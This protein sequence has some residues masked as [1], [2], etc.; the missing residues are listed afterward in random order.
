VNF[1]ERDSAWKR[2]LK[3]VLP[4]A[5]QD[6]LWNGY[7]RLV[8]RKNL[9]VGRRAAPAE[10]S[11]AK[12]RRQREGFFDLYCQGRGLD[13]G[14]GGDP[15]VRGVRGWD[16]E[17]GDA[18][19]LQS[20]Q[21]ASFDFVYSSHTLEHMVDP[22]VSVQNWWR[23]VKPGGYL[24]LYVPHRDLYEKKKTLPSQWN[25]DHKSFLLPEA[26]DPPDTVGLRPLLEAHCVG[27]E[28]VYLKVCDAGHTIT[29]PDV[30]SDGEYSIEAVV[31]KSVDSPA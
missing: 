11:K 1:I 22:A 19:Y 4:Q 7:Q 12:P 28:I 23:V 15:V 13:I 29:T 6:R 18:Q 21:D 14:Y 26:D 8:E 10:T 20:L 31:K 2:A 17:H 25:G 16:F 5:G 27:G 9:A 30:H 24:L 3:G